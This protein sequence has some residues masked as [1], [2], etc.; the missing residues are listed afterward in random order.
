MQTSFKISD[1]FKKGWVN[2]KK[3]WLFL[4]LSTLIY[5]VVYFVLA[6]SGHGFTSV[7]LGLASWIVAQ[8]F[9]IGLYRIALKIEDGG[10]P[11]ATDF[12][13]DFNTFMTVLWA[14]IITGLIIIAGTLLF[15]IPGIIAMLRLSMSIYL[16]LDKKMKAWEAIKESWRITSSYSWKILG[17]VLIAMIVAL[18]SLI[19]LGLGLLISIPF[20]SLSYGVFYRKI[21]Q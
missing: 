9:S 7:F 16:I 15:I 17:M 18:I 3:N 21:S 2:T 11:K 4:V 6:R 12:K 1:V 5:F 10:V 20:L 14:N 8:L 13:T 19:P